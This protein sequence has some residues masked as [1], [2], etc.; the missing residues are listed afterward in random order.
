V[1]DDHIMTPQVGAGIKDDTTNTF[2]GMVMGVVGNTTESKENDS[3]L[4]KVN[5]VDK[6]GLIGYHNGQ[7]SMFI[8]AKTGKATFGLPSKDNGFDEG[9]I[10]LNPGG[11]SKIGN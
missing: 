6:I 4:D 5:K 2:T 8:D 9:R 3:F 11:V 10:E 7:Q 1:G